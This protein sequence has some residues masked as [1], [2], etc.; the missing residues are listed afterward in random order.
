MFQAQ[1]QVSG[2]SN[3]QDKPDPYSHN[4]L[5]IGQYINKKI[6]KIDSNKYYAKG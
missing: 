5:H 2:H 4:T 6:L 1:F 3:E